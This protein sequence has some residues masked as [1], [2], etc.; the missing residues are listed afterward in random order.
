M[1]RRLGRVDYPSSLLTVRFAAQT[2][3]LRFSFMYR[4]HNGYKIHR[5]ISLEKLLKT[6]KLRDTSLAPAMSSYWDCKP[7]AYEGRLIALE[8]MK[9]GATKLSKDAKYKAVAEV[10]EFLGYLLKDIEAELKVTKRDKAKHEAKEKKLGAREV[11]LQFVFVDFLGS[12]MLS[13]KAFIEIKAPGRD[14]ITLSKPVKGGVVSFKGIEIMPVGSLRIMTVSTGKASHI[15]SGVTTYKLGTAK[16]L[17]VRCEEDSKIRKISAG[18]SAQV[19][20]KIGSKATAGA[21]FKILKVGGEV[22]VE[23][24]TVTAGNKSVSWEVR[25]PTGAFKLKVK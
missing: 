1:T 18:N 11:D 20:K 25:V 2:S 3:S 8:K 5:F 4:F 12:P 6:H 15:S 23:G 7:P 17:T 16:N 10:V 14:D 24:E 22:F 19:A 13:Q 9:T 21:D